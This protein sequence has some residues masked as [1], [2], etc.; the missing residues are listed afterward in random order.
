MRVEIP[1][2]PAE[3]VRFGVKRCPVHFIAKTAPRFSKRLA[4]RS[5]ANA[6]QAKMKPMR[7]EKPR[8]QPMA[9]TGIPEYSGLLIL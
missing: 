7:N 3:Y 5:T 8:P 4:K 6:W 2:D 9:D 1:I